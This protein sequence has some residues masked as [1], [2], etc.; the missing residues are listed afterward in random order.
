MFELDSK[1]TQCCGKKMLKAWI[2]AGIY[3]GTGKNMEQGCGH[4]Q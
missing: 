1:D 3:R 4:D 2:R